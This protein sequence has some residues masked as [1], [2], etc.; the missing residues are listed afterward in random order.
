MPAALAA[1][2]H[3]LL[4]A[5]QWLAGSSGPAR[6]HQEREPLLRHQPMIGLRHVNLVEAHELLAVGRG[7]EERADFDHGHAGLTRDRQ[8]PVPQPV[9]RALG[10]VHVV[11]GEDLRPR[12][13]EAASQAREALQ[14][15][16]GPVDHDEEDLLRLPGHH[17]RVEP[18][19]RPRRGQPAALELPELHARVHLREHRGDDRHERA[20]RRPVELHGEGVAD[21]RDPLRGHGLHARDEGRDVGLPQQLGGQ[22]LVVADAE[23]LLAPVPVLAR[24]DLPLGGGRP[25]RGRAAL[26]LEVAAQGQEV[27]VGPRQ[28]ELAEVDGQAEAGVEREQLLQPVPVALHLEV[29]L[30]EARDCAAPARAGPSCGRASQRVKTLTGS[31]SERVRPEARSGSRSAFGSKV[32]ACPSA[33]ARTAFTSAFMSAAWCVSRE[34]SC[35]SVSAPG[36]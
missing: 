3:S 35:A 32:E 29:R 7:G 23:V 1:R 34:A 11:E 13:G 5:P 20:G 22:H 27:G 9:G 18:V 12:L 8:L 26:A 28:A 16:V 15:L 19:H 31:V 17:V 24:G 6:A 30:E 33:Q 10:V 36:E 21:H 4:T 25:D 2:C 14:V